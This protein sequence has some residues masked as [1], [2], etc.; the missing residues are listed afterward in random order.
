MQGTGANDP[1]VDTTTSCCGQAGGGG[2]MLSGG[3][4]N[5]SIAAEDF[6]RDDVDGGAGCD[7]ARID[8]GLDRGQRV[9]D[10]R[11]SF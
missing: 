2:D 6:T 3:V 7:Y 9:E 8:V 1:L 10:K 11:R 5:D 4:G